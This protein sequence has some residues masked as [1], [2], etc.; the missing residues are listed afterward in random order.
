MVWLVFLVQVVQWQVPPRPPGP[1]SAPTPS[2][3]SISSQMRTA[4]VVFSSVST[5]MRLPHGS[6]SFQRPLTPMPALNRF[7]R[8]A[9]AKASKGLSLPRWAHL[10]AC[11]HNPWRL[12]KTRK[13]QR[14][15]PKRKRRLASACK[16]LAIT[17]RPPL[18][19]L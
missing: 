1:T 12:V 2:I 16:T 4:S 11:C 17:H 5:W 3:G 19:L 15:G 10:Y 9:G 6:R 14:R 13:C 18:R 7:Y 8:T